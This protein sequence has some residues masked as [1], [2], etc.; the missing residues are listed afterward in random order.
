MSIPL[1]VTDEAFEVSIVAQLSQWLQD[2][3]LFVSAE[4]PGEKCAH[5]CR[6]L[7]EEHKPQAP[8]SLIG[9]LLGIPRGSIHRYWQEYKSQ[10]NEAVHRG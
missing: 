2:D 10:R 1:T 6:I 4:S 5:A 7:R 3:V 8:F 9:Q